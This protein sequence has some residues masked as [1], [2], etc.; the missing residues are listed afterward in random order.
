MLDSKPVIN[1]QTKLAW[2]LGAAGGSAL[3][4]CLLVL[5]ACAHF[6][7]VFW[8][9]VPG[10]TFTPTR[11]FLADQVISPVG[12]LEFDTLGLVMNYTV[13]VPQALNETTLAAGGEAVEV[14]VS[15]ASGTVRLR[16]RGLAP[17]PHPRAQWTVTDEGITT[18]ISGPQIVDSAVVQNGASTVD[19]A[20]QAEFL[21][22]QAESSLVNARV[23]TH[24]P[25]DFTTNLATPGAVSIGLVPSAVAGQNCS[26]PSLQFGGGNR[27]NSC[28]NGL[29]PNA[30]NGRASIGSDGFV[31][32]SQLPVVFRPDFVGTW[33]ASSNTPFLNNAACVAT[34][35]YYY[36]VKGSG[37]TTLGAYSFWRSKD[38]LVC[39]NGT[40]ERVADTSSGVT[41]IFGRT[42][43]P[44]PQ[45]GDYSAAQFPVNNATL[46][47]VGLASLVVYGPAPTLPNAVLMQGAPGEVV[48]SGAIIE[49]ATLPLPDLAITTSARNTVVDRKG[50]V[51]FVEEGGPLIL[52]INGTANQIISTGSSSVTLSLHQN[53]HTGANVQYGAV[54]VGTREILASGSGA[55]AIPSTG[56]ADFVMTEG[57]Q[58]VNGAT[59]WDAAPTIRSGQGLQLNNAANTGTLD[60]RAAPLA[61]TN[62]EF[63]YPPT[64]GSNQDAL[65]SDGTGGTYWQAAP[66]AD[67]W[68]TFT[69][70]TLSTSP[71]VAGIIYYYGA[72]RGSGQNGTLTEVRMNFRVQRTLPLGTASAFVDFAVPVGTIRSWVT[73]RNMGIFTRS[74]NAAHHGSLKAGSANNRIVATV[75]DLGSVAQFEY[76]YVEY[77]YILNL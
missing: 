1:L 64:L 3:S 54:T 11:Y 35:Y 27:V 73:N 61:A 65:R 20:L 9:L 40:W 5:V 7:L 18:A 30:P 19:D 74:F 77:T 28:T 33:N 55:A 26:Y 22:L 13:G 52:S 6:V 14:V 48:V 37:N 56:A 39:Q 75:N 44:V 66:S 60:L 25:A 59:T 10:M 32:P 69:P 34:E 23:L 8:V 12:G 67:V 17:G 71:N 58:T 49:L 76:W 46:Q 70:T 29:T 68:T 43:A 62:I 4:A 51:A 24:A 57:A 41:S 36:V 47:D 72:W 50:R 38:V 42:G 63:R 16:D 53:I 2:G 15:G 45:L 31:L 21:L